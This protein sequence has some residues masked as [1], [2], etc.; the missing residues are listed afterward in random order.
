M[1]RPHQHRRAWPYGLEMLCLITIPHLRRLAILHG[2]RPHAGGMRANGMRRPSN[3]PVI[4][5][6]LGT[7]RVSI[8]YC[9]PSIIM[10]TIAIRTVLVS[11]VRGL[12]ALGRVTVPMD[13]ITATID[14][15]DVKKVAAHL[16]ILQMRV[17]FMLVLHCK[18]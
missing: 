4:P 5:G 16:Y 6:T 14:V 8:V 2:T 13:G 10:H 11:V 3:V 12:R 17:F 18:V 1:P 7:E 15:L 9:H